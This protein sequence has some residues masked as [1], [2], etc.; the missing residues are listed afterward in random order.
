MHVA[1]VDRPA[2]VKISVDF[3]KIFERINLSFLKIFIALAKW[4]YISVMAW[5]QQRLHKYKVIQKKMP[6]N[7]H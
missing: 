1:R 5:I 2:C 4:Q 7:L 6:E 3:Y